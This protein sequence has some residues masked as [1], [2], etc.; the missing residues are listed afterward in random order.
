[1]T[2]WRQ[3]SVIIKR[4]QFFDPTLPKEIKFENDPKNPDRYFEETF[5]QDTNKTGLKDTS[6]TLKPQ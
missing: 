3:L 2:N 1:M 6:E 4:A 5:L